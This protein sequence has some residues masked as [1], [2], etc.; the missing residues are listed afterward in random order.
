LLEKKLKEDRIFGYHNFED[1]N[2]S[3]FKKELL[4]FE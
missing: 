1:F 3:Y 4:A 2:Q